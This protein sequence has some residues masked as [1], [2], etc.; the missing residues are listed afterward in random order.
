VVPID[1]K[2]G[3]DGSGR[4]RAADDPRALVLTSDAGWPAR[5]LDPVL[6]I[7]RLHFHDYVHVDR[8]TL[9]FVVDDVARL[10]VGEAVYVQYGDDAR[11]RI[12]LGDLEKTW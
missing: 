3:E 5:A 2:Q 8:E 12:R 4:S 10:P 6:H 7:G 11:S 1:V 9:R